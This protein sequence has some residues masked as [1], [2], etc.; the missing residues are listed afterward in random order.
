MPKLPSSIPLGAVQLDS[1]SSIPLYR[2]LY[3]ALRRAILSGQL[4]AGTQLPSTRLLMQELLVSRNTVINAFEQLIA[5]GYL[6]GKSG[7]GTFV[8]QVLPDDL[9]QVDIPSVKPKQSSPKSRAKPSDLSQRGAKLAKASTVLRSSE[10]TS[11]AFRPGLPALDAFPFKLWERL[12]I[13][14]WRNASPEYLGYSQSAGYPPLREAIATYLRAA[15]GVTCQASQVIIVAGAQ[16]AID[17]AA[18]V[19][20]DPGDAAWL[21]DPGYLGARGALQGAGV[22]VVPVPVDQEGLQLEAGLAKAPHPRMVY[23]SPSHQYPLGVTMSLTRRLALLRWAAQA[24]AWILE[25]DYDSEF[26]YVGRP[27]AA[28]QGLDEAGRVIYVGTFSKV[29]YPGLRLGYVVVP[30]DLVDAFSAALALSNRCHA[31]LEQAVLT[32]FMNEGHFARHLRRMRTLYNERRLALIAAINAQLTDW[33]KIEAT[34]AGMHLVGRLAL[35]VDDQYVA[36]QLAKAGIEAPALSSYAFMPLAR[37]G[38]M[39]GYAGTDVGTIQ[40]GIRQMAN[41]FQMRLGG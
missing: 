20:L 35:G 15:R 6:E 18:R 39:L 4:T 16:Q 31:W 13:R 14:H 41:V 24:K 26:R 10:L 27:L 33:L 7:S 3:K 40:A 28:L 34:E 5:E 22:Q 9:F 36:Q 30:P 19:L 11:Q 29:L 21:E 37:G 12:I 2:Q 8:C 23:I 38:L 1:D 17:L 32:D 25:D